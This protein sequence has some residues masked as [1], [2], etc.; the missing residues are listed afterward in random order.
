MKLLYVLPEYG[1]EVRGGIAT[2]YANLLPVLANLG[3]EVDV[4]VADPVSGD[5]A[6]RG[7]EGRIKISHIT[8]EAM[9]KAS[10]RL[11]QFAAAPAARR[12]LAMAYAAFATAR[13]G[14]GYDL[15][16]TTDFG[17]LFAPWLAAGGGPP[18]VVQLHGSAGQIDYHDPIAGNELSG[19][20]A[21][22]LETAFLGRAEELQSYGEANGLEWGRLLGRPIAHVWPG[23]SKGQEEPAEP[24][25]ALELGRSGIVVGRIQHWKGPETLCRAASLLGAR[26]PRILWVGRDHTHAET[27]QPMSAHLARTYPQIWGTRILPVGEFPREVVAGIQRAARFVVVPSLWDTFNLGAVEGMW[28]G[29]V[30][31]CAEGAGAAG[32]IEHGVNG[33]RFPTGD[34]RRLADLLARV[35]AMSD[36]ERDAMGARAR[37]TVERTLDAGK[38]ASIRLTRYEAVRTRAVERQSSP[39]GE[40]AFGACRATP[41]LG[42]LE[43]LPLRLLLGYTM[44]RGLTKLLKVL[45]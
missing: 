20:L 10:G 27:A 24:P 28:A 35:D 23:W 45:G 30:V 32:L 43:Q 33:W 21:R 4:L 44:R 8:P 34:A 11:S 37:A 39:W 14:D 12:A 2:F 7:A 3:C 1:R 18:I 38:I 31:I 42:F 22:L 29:K 9:A 25:A 41:P 40:S 17:L 5:P 16:E 36:A 26:A 15:V 6:G 19:L 13:G